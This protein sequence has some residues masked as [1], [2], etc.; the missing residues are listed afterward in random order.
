MYGLPVDLSADEYVQLHLN[1][2]RA[3]MWKVYQDVLAAD[4]ASGKPGPIEYYELF[5]G[6]RKKASNMMGDQMLARMMGL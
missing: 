6:D 4:I 2:P 5:A 3:R 1:L